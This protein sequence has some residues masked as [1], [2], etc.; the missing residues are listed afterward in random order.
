MRQIAEQIVD[1]LLERRV[2]DWVIGKVNDV[3]AFTGIGTDSM[4]LGKNTE[5][6][7]KPKYGK[8]PE[9]GPTGTIFITKPKPRAPESGP[10]TWDIS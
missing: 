1:A 8:K 5:K 9:Y 10:R 2:I 4:G 6:G 7:W 3:K